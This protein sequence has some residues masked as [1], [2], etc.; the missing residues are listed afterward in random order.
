[1]RWM[2]LLEID[3]QT[4]HLTEGGGEGRG[5]GRMGGKEG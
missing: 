5:E 2:A 4:C 3:Q 1:M